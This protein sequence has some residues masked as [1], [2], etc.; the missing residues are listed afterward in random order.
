MNEYSKYLI[1]RKTNALASFNKWY[2]LYYL[3]ELKTKL[4]ILAKK[5]RQPK[6]SKPT[7]IMFTNGDKRKIIKLKECIT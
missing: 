1:G 3:E 7:E 6:F 2:F 5:E 4:Y